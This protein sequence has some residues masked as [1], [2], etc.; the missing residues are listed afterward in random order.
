[1]SYCCVY[2]L[3]ENAVRV[4]DSSSS[5][6]SNK[7]AHSLV[8]CVY[9]CSIRGRSC[10]IT[11]TWWKSLMGQGLN[12]KIDDSSNKCL[13]KVDIKPWVFSKRNVCCV[14]KI[15]LLLIECDISIPG[16]PCL[17]VH[18][19]SKIVMQV[20]RLKLKF[21]GNN[22]ILFYG[23]EVECN[24]I[25]AGGH[26]WDGVVVI[27]SDFQSLRAIENELID[28]IGVLVRWNDGGLG[29]C[30]AYYSLSRLRILD[31]SNNAIN[32]RFPLS[33]TNLSS[34]V[35]QNLENNQIEDHM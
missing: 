31:L 22:A 30:S 16:E 2:T 35:S 17:I 1:M 28:S 12:V 27:Q 20:K 14:G 25:K 19:N 3:S 4:A 21:R 34:L 5:L 33:F 24:W 23:L 10:L 18:I 32:G 11:I 13:C 9:Q 26:L 6:S 15:Q 7:T 29:D 8:I